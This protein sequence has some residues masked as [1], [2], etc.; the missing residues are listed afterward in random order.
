MTQ[1]RK[2]LVWAMLAALAA[3][4]TYFGLRGYVS[5]DMLFNFGNS[6]YC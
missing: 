3:L 6:F 4:V 5:A 2:I 1:C